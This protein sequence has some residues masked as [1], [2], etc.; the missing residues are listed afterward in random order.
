M[1]NGVKYYF[2][3]AVKIKFSS[4][5]TKNVGQNQHYVLVRLN[6]DNEKIDFYVNPQE[7]EFKDY[8]WADIDEA[9]KKIVYFKKDAYIKAVEY[10]KPYI[11][12]IK[13]AKDR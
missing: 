10:F 8:R 3:D 1:P 12:E 6:N 9:P 2:P 5:G 4:N 13:K 11:D 7:V